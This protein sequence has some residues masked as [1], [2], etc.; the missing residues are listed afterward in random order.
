MK[1]EP[2]VPHL[3]VVSVTGFGKGYRRHEEAGKV[4]QLPDPTICVQNLFWV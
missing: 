1:I 2:T 4:F 3:D